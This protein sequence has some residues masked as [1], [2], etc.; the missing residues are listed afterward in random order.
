MK[1]GH[2]VTMKN[3]IVLYRIANY[4]YNKRVPLVPQVI[5]LFIRLIYGCFLPHTAKLGSGC[6]VGYGGLAVIVSG[7]AII[8]DNVEV[9]AGALI[10]GN[11]REDGVPVI[12][13]NVYIGAGA[14]VLGPIEIGENVV[15]S[16]NSV[17]LK[18]V[19]SNSVTAGMP[20]KIVKS[21]INI[22]EFLYHR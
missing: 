15:I 5:T 1:Q 2:K 13:D 3:P 4:L 9:G 17:V 18:S 14:K 11:A 16:A 20:A 7:K 8:G 19:P 21:N 12:G 10:G 6:S 22:S